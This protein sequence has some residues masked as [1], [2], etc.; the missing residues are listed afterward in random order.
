[1]IGVQCFHDV[2]L[3][4]ETVRTTVT[5]LKGWAV[6]VFMREHNV[7]QILKSDSNHGVVIFRRNDDIPRSLVKRQVVPENRIAG[8]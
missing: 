8:D 4:A 1:M 2:T 7:P 6:I 5:L 3:T